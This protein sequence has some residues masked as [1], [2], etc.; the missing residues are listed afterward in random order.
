[1]S[2]VFS[3]GLNFM[4]ISPFLI[5]PSHSSQANLVSKT[6]KPTSKTSKRFLPSTDNKSNKLKLI[7]LN[8]LVFLVDFL[9][10]FPLISTGDGQI[11]NWGWVLDSLTT[12]RTLNYYKRWPNFVK[13]WQVIINNDD[14]KILMILKRNTPLL[15]QLW[16]WE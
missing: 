12:A 10:Y 7:S 16:A 5:T 1:M 13:K 14:W 3:R 8:L 9:W 4:G 11:L 2:R 15:D 6:V